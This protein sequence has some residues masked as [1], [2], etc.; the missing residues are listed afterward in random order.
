MTT[1]RLT[2]YRIHETDDG[3]YV[4]KQYI[5]VVRC[6]FFGLSKRIVIK[7]LRLD[8]YG[9]GESRGYLTM[10]RAKFKTIEEAREFINRLKNPIN[11]YHTV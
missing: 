9:C 4:E 8:R 2:K 5:E 1:K 3:F 11:K 10:P 6:G 7:W